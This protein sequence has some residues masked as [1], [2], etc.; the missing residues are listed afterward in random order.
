MI[1]ETMTAMETRLA[2]AGF[3]RLSRSSLVNLARVR[4]LQPMAAGEYCVILQSG[5]RLNMTCSLHE[6][7]ARLG[8]D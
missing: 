6:L 5:A 8:H 7:Q 4:E 2:E 3:M 1:R